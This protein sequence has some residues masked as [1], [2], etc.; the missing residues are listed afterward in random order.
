VRTLACPILLA[1]LVAALLACG[2]HA[3]PM[4]AATVEA[5]GVRVSLPSPYCG[6]HQNENEPGEVDAELHID[7]HTPQPLT[8]DA[9]KVRLLV[10]GVGEQPWMRRAEYTIAPGQ[11]RRIWLHAYSNF[12][13]CTGEMS[14][15]LEGALSSAGQPIELQPLP[16][17]L[18][19]RG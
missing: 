3:P 10:A 16:I 5:R 14:L 18:A 8:L 17:V 2:C 15:S 9:H 6:A 7:N 13:R 12:I 19:P 11:S 4:G 1:P